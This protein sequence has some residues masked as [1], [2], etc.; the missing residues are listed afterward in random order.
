MKLTEKKQPL[1]WSLLEI[2]LYFGA[3]KKSVY[4]QESCNEK[5]V[6]NDYP[7]AQIPQMGGKGML[8]NKKD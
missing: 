8:G 4:I 1:Q 3:G 6:Q 2:K 5:Y 7:R